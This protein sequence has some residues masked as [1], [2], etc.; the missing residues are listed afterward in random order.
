MT[1]TVLFLLKKALCFVYISFDV[2]LTLT[3]EKA[4]GSH[5]FPTLFNSPGLTVLVTRGLSFFPLLTD[6]TMGATVWKITPE[7]GY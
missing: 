4:A 5:N 1:L 7:M 2:R 6:P 3:S